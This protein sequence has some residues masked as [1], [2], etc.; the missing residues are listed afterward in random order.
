[1]LIIIVIHLVLTCPTITVYLYFCLFLCCI[2]TTG[3]FGVV[4][5]GLLTRKCDTV[6]TPVAVKTLAGMRE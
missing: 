3:N 4:Y 5:S 6:P 1:M 2:F